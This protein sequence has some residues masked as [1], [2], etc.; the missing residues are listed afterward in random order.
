MATH[1]FYHKVDW[2]G[3]TSAAILKQAI[4]DAI[5]HAFNYNMELPANLAS[6]DVVYFVDVAPQ[7]FTKLCELSEKVSKIVVLDHHKSLID[8]ISEH[9]TPDNLVVRYNLKRAACEI[10]WEYFYPELECPVEVRLLGQYDSW[11]DTIVKQLD[12]DIDWSTVLSYQFGIRLFELDPSWMRTHLFDYC[13]ESAESTT[14]NG[15][16]ILQYQDNQ[17]TDAMRYSFTMIINGHRCLCVN[18]GHR[19]SNIFKSIW[20]ESKYDIM[21]AFSFTGKKWSYSVYSTKADVDC[22]AFAKS[23]G[24]GGHKGAAGFYTDTCIVC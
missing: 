20:D 22:S 21:L 18:T 16:I 2:D 6:E 13:H 15:K 10:V 4:P 11:R 14:A 8:F 5:L 19:N 12:G 24:G 17:N 3:V 23:Y 9:P 7:P 1:C